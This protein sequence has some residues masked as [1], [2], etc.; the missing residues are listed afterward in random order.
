MFKAAVTLLNIGD[1][2]YY[3]N[4][5]APFLLL[6]R[7]HTSKFS[8]T[9]VIDNVHMLMCMNPKF[10][11]TSFSLTNFICWCERINKFSLTSFHCTVS[12]RTRKK[13]TTRRQFVFSSSLTLI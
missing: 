8:L 2:E 11:L 5:S 1:H 6:S 7:L 10:S 13:T 3:V 4:Q 9:S 12:Q